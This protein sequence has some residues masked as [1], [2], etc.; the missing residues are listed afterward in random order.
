MGYLFVNTGRLEQALECFSQL[1]KI[2]SPR[3][4]LAALLGRG[5]AYALKGMLIEAVEDFSDAIKSDPKCADAWKRR[6]QARAAMGRDVEA[7]QDL[8]VAQSITPEDADILFQRGLV[9][10][11]Q[12]NYRRALEDFKRAARMDPS[13]TIWNHLG[14]SQVGLGLPREVI[15]R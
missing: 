3:I 15:D 9:L 14:L 7:I 8:A 12:K 10:Y 11:K 13:A 1:I 4:P 2:L 5:T 6:G